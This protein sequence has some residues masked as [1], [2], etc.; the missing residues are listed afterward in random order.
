MGVD[1]DVAAVDLHPQAFEAHAFDIAV[2]AHRDDGPLGLQT[3]RLAADLDID[4]DPAAV[5]AS[6]VTLAA[7]R[8]FRPRFSKAFCAAAETSSSSTGRMR[9]RA[10]MTVTSAPKAL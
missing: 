4:G 2:N 6:L 3:L 10:S 9:S 1:H 5:L 8:N 7:T